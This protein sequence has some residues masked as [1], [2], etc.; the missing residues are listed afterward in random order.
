VGYYKIKI[1]PADKLFSNYIRQKAGWSCQK[2]GKLCRINGEWIA[3]LEAS[4]YWTRS[5]ESTRF[6]VLN[7]YSLCF[8]CHK[9]M[10]ERK[11][12]EDGEYDLW[13]KELLG[14]KEYKKLKI[15]ANTYCKKD[16]K[17]IL[18]WLKSL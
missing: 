17:L 2:C 8:N 12:S 13:V 5:H 11:N 16:D 6:D 18:M 14:E 1:R 10:G 9:R 7:V 15:R 4:H 3:K